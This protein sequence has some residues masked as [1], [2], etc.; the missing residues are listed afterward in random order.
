MAVVV[1]SA[2]ASCIAES[3]PNIEHLIRNIHYSAAA[4]NAVESEA[5]AN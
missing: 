4:E 5:A 2:N 1:E 3:A